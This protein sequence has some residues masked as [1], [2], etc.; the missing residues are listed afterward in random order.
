MEGYTG[1]ISPPGMYVRAQY[2]YSADDPTSL[3]FA[4]GDII[5]VLTQLES[6][7]WDGVIA[8]QRGWFPSNYCVLI[9]DQEAVRLDQGLPPTDGEDHEQILEQDSEGEHDQDEY[10]TEYAHHNLGLSSQATRSLQRDQEEAAFWI[11]QATPDGRLFYFNTLTGV[12]T[13]E[14]PLESPLSAQG[15]N[16]NPFR[17]SENAFASTK[18]DDDPELSTSETE[19]AAHLRS[20]LPT[21]RTS[22]L[23]DGASP[24]ASVESLMHNGNSNS[25]TLVSRSRADTLASIGKQSQTS[26]ATFTT[27]GSTLIGDQVPKEFY[28][29]DSVVLLTWNRML[30][31]MKKAVDRYR[32]AVNHRERSEFVRRAGD[33]SDQ[34]RLILAAGSGTTDNHS[35]TPSVIMAN[36]ALYPHFRDMMSR[37]S[38]LV[39]SSHIAAADYP[40]GDQFAKCL[41]EAEGVLNGVYG[42]IEIARQQR[43]EEIP[44]LYPGFVAG[45]AAGGNWR[46]NGPGENESA[47]SSARAVSEQDG[48][49]ESTTKL[50]PVILERMNDLTRLI[51]ASI[52]RLD[53]YLVVQDKLITHI[54]H[55]RLSDNV[56]NACGKIVDSYKTWMAIMES[57]NLSSIAPQVQSP[58]IQDFALQKQRVYVYVAEL[59]ISC[60]AIAAPLVDEWSQ[61]RGDSLEERI[62]R[63]RAVSKTLETATS[64]ITN[65]LQLYL[66]MLPSND[67]Q[68][69]LNHQAPRSS[70]DRSL[71]SAHA[72]R[73]STQA[74]GSRSLLNDIS[75]AVSF[76]EP[77]NPAAGLYVHSDSSK[78]KKFFGEVPNTPTGMAD[79]TPWYLRLDYE[80]EVQYDT[81]LEPPAIK[82]GTLTGLVEQLTRHDKYDAAFKVTFLLTYRSFTSAR[83]LFEMLIQ[84][85]SIQP[86]P[87]L[88]AEELK[89]WVEKKQGP[90]R[91][92]IV[93]VLKSWF[94]SYWMEGTDDSSIQ[95]VHDIRRFVDNTVAE[96]ST[97]GARPL[98]TVIEQ[99]MRGEDPSAKRLVPNSVDPP[100][101]IL[102]KNMK[103][104][105]FQDIDP[106]EFARQLTIIESR[107]YAKVRPQECL[108]KAWQ[109]KPVAGEPD[110]ASNVKA[111]ILHANRL[112]N[113]VAEMILAQ[114]D[115]KK[116]VAVIKHFVNVADRCLQMSNFSTLTSI[117]S[118]LSTAPIHRLHRTWK[119][120]SKTTMA[121]LEKMRRLMGSTKNFAEYREALHAANPPCIPFFGVYLTDLTFIDDGIPSMIKKTDLINFFKRTKTAE[122][123]REIQTYQN[124]SY[125][126]KA[127]S[128]L[129]DYILNMM[130]SAGDV[131]EMYERS[132]QVEPRER[133]DEKIARYVPAT[134]PRSQLSD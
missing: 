85:W 23:S 134:S 30:E 99:R 124:V 8:G 42:F 45:S 26:K 123:I 31:D 65:S 41:Q 94:D 107:L 59:V 105:K 79:D 116:R 88:M 11:P 132:L 60:Q 61:N 75:S 54:K 32:Q 33:M 76:S 129:Q 39:L 73:S 69:P 128:E 133:E 27:G 114:A 55:K 48:S 66:D 77:G 127:V 24:A 28:D 98:L 13:M 70:Q 96:S 119:E 1:S 86:P 51:V 115:V 104:L 90:I 58:R 113:W 67:P 2:D 44:R 89:I 10:D 87:G 25:T 97:P 92:R 47:S 102:P 78:V 20:S 91:F 53:E 14:L 110:I 131:H 112:T 120:V 71:H 130:V 22:Y 7:W 108:N 34:L 101:S 15:G 109:R 68:E 19:E 117:I 40:P 118:A 5:Q 3:S 84:R 103:K 83:D 82:G 9:P 52:R 6:G 62:M 29:D 4:A 18:R 49:A 56:C 126:Y 125:P 21:K 95:L 43:G 38:K 122:V 46:N 100:P 111:L 81:K 17:P 64:A 16:P 74:G 50:E 35:G 93:N 80:G 106:Q 72:S 37:F 57:I 36:K 121:A 63:T 12:S